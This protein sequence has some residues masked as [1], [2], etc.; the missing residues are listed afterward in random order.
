MLFGVAFT[1]GTAGNLIFQWAQNTTGAFNTTL[2]QYSYVTG[3]RI[4]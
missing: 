2:Y 1:A 3:A 4:G